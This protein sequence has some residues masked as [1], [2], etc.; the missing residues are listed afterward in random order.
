MF[1]YFPGSKRPGSVGIRKRWENKIM[2]DVE[3]FGIK[4]WRKDTKSRDKWRQLIN[5]NVRINPVHM[6]IKNILMDY[7]EHAHKRRSEES[8]A[9]RGII[10]RKVTEILNKDINNYYTC[11]NCG[12]CF[13]PQGI[14]GHVKSCAKIWCKKH[15]ITL[16]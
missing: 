11:P 3:K 9:K 8:D 16:K 10:R 15:K 13:K 5:Q 2:E 7:K 6:N 1:S 12:R 4:N 14:T